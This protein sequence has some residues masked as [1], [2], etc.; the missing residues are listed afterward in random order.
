[1]NELIKNLIN[2]CQK[3]VW[4]N[5]AYNGSPEFDG[6]ELDAEKLAELIIKEYE[7]FL[8]D[9]CPWTNANEEGPMKGW[10]VQ[11]VARKHFGVKE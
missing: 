4:I 7:Q 5:N 8:P 2:Q 6:Y 9:I 3:E 1:M 10:H 11:F